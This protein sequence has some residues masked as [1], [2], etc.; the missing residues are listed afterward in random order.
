[1]SPSNF[2]YYERPSNHELY[3]KISLAKNCLNSEKWRPLNHKLFY[4]DCNSLDLCVYEEQIDALT[5]VLE[6]LSPN[7]YCGGRPPQ[8]SY[9]Q[10]IFGSELFAFAVYYEPLG[11][12]IYIKFAFKREYLFLVSFHQSRYS[13]LNERRCCDE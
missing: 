10:E 12:E 2:D 1:M 4:E 8:S 7:D 13:G 3:K 6:V 9:E 5:G 11:K